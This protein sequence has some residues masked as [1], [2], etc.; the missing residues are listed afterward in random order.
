MKNFKKLTL[1][2]AW[3]ASATIT[4][5]MFKQFQS[6]ATRCSQMI[7][8]KINAPSSQVA[9]DKAFKPSVY[10]SALEVFRMQTERA[11]EKHKIAAYLS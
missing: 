10:N 8:P 9:I 7:T 6:L 2:A 5:P 3:V 11:L 1:L 4:Q